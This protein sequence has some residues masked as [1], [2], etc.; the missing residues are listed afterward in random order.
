MVV[1]STEMKENGCG[2]EHEKTNII[3]VPLILG[4]IFAQAMIAPYGLPI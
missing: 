2:E 4:Q 1:H 3:L